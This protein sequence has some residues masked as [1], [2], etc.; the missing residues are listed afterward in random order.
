MAK[1]RPVIQI[2]DNEW[3]TIDWIGQHEE[4]CGC[5]LRHVVDYRVKDG[6]LQFR[7]HNKGGKKL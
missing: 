5:G 6:K 7:A 2:H 3:V 1:K 4:C